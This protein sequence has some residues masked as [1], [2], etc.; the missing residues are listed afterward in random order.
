M[1]D[2]RGESEPGS[3]PFT[4]W[5]GVDL[6]HFAALIAVSTNRSFGGAAATLHLTQSAI[7]HQIAQLEERVGVPLVDRRAAGGPNLTAAGQIVARHASAIFTHLSAVRAELLAQSERVAS[8]TIGVFPSAGAAILPGLLRWLRRQSPALEV[9]IHEEPEDAA[10]LRMVDSGRLDL[11]FV[12]LPVDDERFHTKE[13]VEDPWCVVVPSGGR[14]AASGT[15]ALRGLASLPLIGLRHGAPLQQGESRL[16]I[17]GY[18]ADVVVRVDDIGTIQGL[19]AAGLGVAILPRM[20]VTVRHPGVSICTLAD[21]VA[22]RRIGVAWS[23]LRQPTAAVAAV[24][25]ATVATLA[26]A[27]GPTALDP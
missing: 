25:E 21:P 17:A 14:L 13:V 12:V 8:V 20:L 18:D 1:P 9:A 22:P 24:V 26:Q 3:D 10:L 6:R 15:L 23:A 2:T 5:P 16:K 27:L 11:A 19:V 7:S 4:P